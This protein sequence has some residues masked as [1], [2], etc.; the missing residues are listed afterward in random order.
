MGIFFNIKICYNNLG[1]MKIDERTILM[2]LKG[3]ACERNIPIFKCNASCGNT[4]R[5]DIRL[6]KI[7]KKIFFQA[8]KVAYASQLKLHV[9]FKFR[10]EIRKPRSEWFNL[11]M[12]KALS[13][14]SYIEDIAVK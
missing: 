13:P 1:E 7:I 6:N 3:R 10:C 5:T 8:K 2:I 14:F 9:C 12:R 4:M 11:T